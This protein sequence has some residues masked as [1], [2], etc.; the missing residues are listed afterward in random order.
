M[1]DPTEFVEGL[2]H[3][4]EREANFMRGLAMSNEVTSGASESLQLRAAELDDFI[5]EATN[6]LESA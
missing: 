4:L 2:L 3:R 5:E 6:T 1:E